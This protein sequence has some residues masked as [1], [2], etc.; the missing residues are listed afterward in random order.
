MNFFCK[1]DLNYLIFYVTLV[2]IMAKNTLL[3][4]VSDLIY[5]FFHLNVLYKFPLNL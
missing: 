4:V 3:T 2:W 1:M 5:T